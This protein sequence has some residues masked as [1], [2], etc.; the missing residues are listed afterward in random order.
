MREYQLYKPKDLFI[1]HILFNNQWIFREFH[2][3]FDV[4]HLYSWAWPLVRLVHKW[5]LSENVLIVFYMMNNICCLECSVLQYEQ[6]NLGFFFVEVLRL[7]F[8]RG[9]CTTPKCVLLRKKVRTHS[10]SNLFPL[11]PFPSK[12]LVRLQL[13]SFE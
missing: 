8:E 10:V 7:R 11:K 13:F 9:T 5:L 12:L 4:F 6:I 1:E 2:W 3:S